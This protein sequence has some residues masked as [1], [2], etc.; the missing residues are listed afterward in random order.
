MFGALLKKHAMGV[1]VA[2]SCAKRL[3]ALE[4]GE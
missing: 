4:T 3:T 1:S 2:N